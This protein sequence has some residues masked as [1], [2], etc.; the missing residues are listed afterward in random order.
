[1]RG[2]LFFLLVLQCCRLLANDQYQEAYP[3]YD[4]SVFITADSLLDA[5]DYPP[6]L[7]HFEDLLQSNSKLSAQQKT[8]ATIKVAML[9]RKLYNNDTA[10]SI[11]NLAERLVDKHLP[12]IDPIRALCYHEKGELSSFMK[13]NDIAKEFIQKAIDQRTQIFGDSSFVRA[14]SVIEMG[15][16]YYY[17]LNQNEL[18][19]FYFE[20]AFTLFTKTSSTDN[21]YLALAYYYM[22]VVYWRRFEFNY[23]IAFANSAIQI[24]LNCT[25]PKFNFIPS[26]YNALSRISNE[27]HQYKDAVEYGKKALETVMKYD[28]KNNWKRNFSIY[29]LAIAYHHS[30]EY[31]AAI[32]LLEEILQE[33]AIKNENDSYYLPVFNLQLIRSYANQGNKIKAEELLEEW[34]PAIT[35]FSNKCDEEAVLFKAVLAE[36]YEILGGYYEASKIVESAIYCYNNGLTS[37]E[38]QYQKL[39][40]TYFHLLQLQNDY[41]LETADYADISGNLM[42]ADS[43]YKLNKLHS[44]W[45]TSK[46]QKGASTRIFYDYAID[47]LYQKNKTEDIEN[48]PSIY[49]YI[50]SNYA[51]LIYESIVNDLLIKKNNLSA[52][53][54]KYIKEIDKKYL[55]LQ[56]EIEVKKTKDN[57]LQLERLKTK[58]DQFYQQLESNSISRNDELFFDNIPTIEELQDQLDSKEAIVIFYKG[59]NS[60]YRLSIQK[61]SLAIDQ[62]DVEKD[63]IAFNRYFSQYQPRLFSK[64]E[65]ANYDTLANHLYQKL[66]NGLEDQS[67]ITVI[68]DGILNFLAIEALTYQVSDNHSNFSQLNYVLNKHIINYACSTSHLFN[69]SKPNKP[70]TKFLSVI[71]DSL[72]VSSGKE[73]KL[74]A[75]L[76]SKKYTNKD[77]TSK[78]DLLNLMD[79]V[80]VIHF[81]THGIV[82]KSHSLFNYLIVN[83]SIKLYENEISSTTTSASLVFLNACESNIGENVVGEG[84]FSFA[85]SFLQA[86]CPSIIGSLWQISQTTSSG[87]AIDFYKAAD[88]KDVSEALAIAKR[89]YLK[90]HQNKMTAHPYYWAGLISIGN[91]SPIIL[92][93]K[94]N[95]VPLLC[96]LLV[97]LIVIISLF[98]LLLHY[99]HRS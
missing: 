2:F 20:E 41:S 59:E 31:A 33:M 48:I 74:L 72:L 88:K 73:A 58:R 3:G 50:E 24:E 54:Q 43:L 15:E 29:N 53:D 4:L 91:D 44:N 23:A 18:A 64:V 71:P 46:L 68:T 60:Y 5:Y 97:G 99:K 66:F 93:K 94:R 47:F 79:N 95:L 16:L 55:E 26:V 28:S 81:G 98:K 96:L 90:E 89:K 9:Y 61:D 51:F 22:A 80:D 52:K 37:S 84:V 12:K 13:K 30:E 40:D 45:N 78:D 25:N 32:N 76:F 69:T 38:F 67:K 21:H 19:S 39:A 77:Y 85:R 10:W 65:V 42:K 83:D 82:D 87:I 7:N 8:Y 11:I 86:G 35:N 17:N 34:L 92:A 70:L 14:I 63:V 49:H 27:N 56:N 1:M 6:A 62:F 36:I 57:L 75:R